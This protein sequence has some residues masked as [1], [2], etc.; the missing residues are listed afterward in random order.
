MRC[1]SCSGVMNL[2]DSASDEGEAVNELRCAR[3]G[4][5]YIKS[6]LVFDGDA[7]EL[8]PFI[9]YQ[10][11]RQQ[12]TAASTKTTEDSNNAQIR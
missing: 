5:Q 8:D 9:N 10:L 12:N 11:M 4:D 2:V 3:C 1:S 7:F 6:E